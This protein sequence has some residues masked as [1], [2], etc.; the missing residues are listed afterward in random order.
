MTDH[1]VTLGGEVTGRVV[2]LAGPG[3]IEEQAIEALR[4]LAAAGGLGVAN[5]WGAKGVFAWDSPHHLGTCGLQARDFEL[6]GFAAADVIVATGLDADEAPRDRFA[7]APVIDVAPAQLGALVGRIRAT[8]PLRNDLY[9]RLAAIARPG[10]VD[11]KVPLHPARAVAD[12]GAVLPA[13]GLVAAEPGLAGLWVARTFP[14]PPLDP[15]AARR[16]SVPARRDPGLAVDRA[17]AAARAGRPAIYVTASE[18]DASA[19]AAIDRAASRGV[20]LAV[21]V[22]RPT[23]RLHDVDEHASRL[24]EALA[25]SGPTWVEVPVDLG[26]T[27]LLI[28]AAG[29]VVAWDGL[30]ES[31]R[32]FE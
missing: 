3:V 25:T 12:L 30:E 4:D 6:L 7:L 20:D 28:D 24:R 27:R 22:W 5:T 16:V 2:V 15:G 18:P 31:E 9:P 17:V 23:G 13:G 26:D 21:V 8:D 10:Y 32:T 1:A 19:R 29:V 14:T 11:D